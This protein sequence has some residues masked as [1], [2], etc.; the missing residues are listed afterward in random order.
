M[1]QH[2]MTRRGRLRSV[3]LLEP[4]R[5]TIGS[6]DQYDFIGLVEEMRRGNLTITITIATT[7]LGRVMRNEIVRP[8]SHPIHEPLRVT[9][10][11][12]LLGYWGGA[13]TIGAA[14]AR[15]SSRV[16]LSGG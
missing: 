13:C 4:T 12:H 9:F 11:P 10:R 8:V 14:A 2:F 7:S 15:V 1:G 5:S 6:A 16:P 3:A